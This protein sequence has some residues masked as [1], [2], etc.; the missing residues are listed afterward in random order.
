MAFASIK[1][2]QATCRKLLH[3]IIVTHNG[4]YCYTLLQPQWKLL[5]HL[6]VFLPFQCWWRKFGE[7]TVTNNIGRTRGRARSEKKTLFAGSV[8]TIFVWDWSYDQH[9]ECS[10]SALCSQ[11]H[12][13]HN[14]ILRNCWSNEV[15]LRK[16]IS[17]SIL[18]RHKIFIFTLRMGSSVV[19][20]R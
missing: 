3:G 6:T 8:P 14:I 20:S 15:A 18:S 13:C 2:L 17:Y 10:T 19:G 11:E 4:N 1:W 16:A 7:L 9:T 12:F 5:G